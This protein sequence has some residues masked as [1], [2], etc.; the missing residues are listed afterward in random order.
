MDEATYRNQLVQQLQ[1]CGIPRTM[2]ES[3]V[4]YVVVGRPTG[5]FLA[6][7]LCN[8][9]I[10]AVKKADDLNIQRLRDYVS[11]LEGC[12]PSMCYGSSAVYN[13]W[14]RSGGVTGRS[15]A[16]AEGTVAP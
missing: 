10:L 8:D 5:S 13:E 16:L 2:W 11:F 12:A 1:A 15:R 3:L 6:A 14:I 9:L 7:L 4:E